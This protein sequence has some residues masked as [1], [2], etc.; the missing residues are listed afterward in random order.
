MKNEWMK[1][2]DKM[3]DGD[4]KEASLYFLRMLAYVQRVDYFAESKL[5][6]HFKVDVIMLK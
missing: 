2:E 4:K 6:E 1:D 3:K 5:F